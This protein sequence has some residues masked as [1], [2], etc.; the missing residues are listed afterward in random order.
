MQC[1][2]F[3]I[4]LA[5]LL[6]EPVP[7]WKSDIV[8]TWARNLGDELWRLSEALTKSDQIRIKYKQMNASVKQ[9]NGKVILDSSLTSVSAM[10]TRKINAVK[11]IHATAEKLAQEFNYSMIE[12]PEYK[13][14]FQY[15]SAKYSNF[16]YEQEQM[17]P[18][19]IFS[20]PRFAI[21]NPHFSNVTLEKDSHFYDINVNTNISCVHVPTNIYYEEKDALNA[22]LWSR[23]LNDIFTK[24]YKSDPSLS[25][26]YFGSSHGILRFFP[27]MPWNKIVVDTYDCRVRSWYIEAAT[28]S[29]D[30]IILFDVSGSMTGF[31]NYV[32]RRTLRSLLSTLS[33]NDYVNV[34]TFKNVT[35]QVV[36]CFVDLVQATPENIKTIV[37]ALEPTDGG[38]NHKVPLDG[39]ANLTEAYIKAF[40]T[41]KE[42]RQICN[43][44]STQGCNQLVMVI[45]DYVP[46]NLTEVFEEYN[47]EVVDN[48]TYIPVRVFTFLIGKEVTNVAEI[49]W[50]ACL[51]RGYFVHIHSVEEVQQQVLKYINVIAR[52]MILSKENPPP[53]WTHANIDDTRTQNWNLSSDMGK[54]DEDKLVT[55]VAIPAFDYKYNSEHNDAILLGVAGTDVP[56]DSIAKLAQPH[57]LGVNGYPLIVSN[58]GYLLLH[59][60]LIATIN[61]VLQENYNS[62]DFVEV[63]Q[64]DDGKGPRELGDKIKQ[65]RQALVDGVDGNMT[66]VEVLFHY[67]NMRR[68]ARV[69]HDYFY[70]KLEGT[71]FSMGIS[72]PKGYGDTELML[73]DNPLEAKQGKELTGINVTDYFRFSFRVHPDWVYCKYHYLEGHE[74]ETSEIEIWRFLSL[75]SKNEID[76]TK[77]QYT[78]QND[79]SNFTIE[80]HCGDATT[81][82]DLDDYYCTE[83]LVKQLVFDA[84]LTTPYFKEWHATTSEWDLARKYNVSVRFIAT[85]SGLTRW[86]YIFD[87][88]K[89]EYVNDDGTVEKNCSGKV[90]GDDYHNAIEE[91]WYKAAVLQHMIN[92]E[93]L[94]IATRLPILDDTIK[95]RPPVENED[96]DITMTATYAMFYRDGDSETPASVVG[97]Q[98]SYLKFHERFGN[99][100]N[101]TRGSG[102]KDKKE[103]VCGNG[104]YDCFLVDSSGYVVLSYPLNT[105]QVGQFF[106][107][108][109]HDTQLVLQYLIDMTVYQHV[110]LFNYQALCPISILQHQNSGWSLTSPFSI[111]GNFVRWLLSEIALLIMNWNQYTYA[112]TIDDEDTTTAM[113]PE[114]NETIQAEDDKKS[115][116]T[117]SCDHKIML[118]ILNQ[119]F[120]LENNGLPRTVHS[121]KEGD[122]HPPFWASYVAKT[123]MLLVVVERGDRDYLGDCKSDDD[124]RP[125]CKVPP[126]TKPRATEASTTSREPCHKLDLGRL[127]RRRLEG[128]FTYHEGERNITTCSSS[129]TTRRNLLL[130]L[131]TT[132]LGARAHTL[133]S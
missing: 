80:T 82:L 74:A 102:D 92:K 18:P 23:E 123:N 55:S 20:P 5:L 122:C 97:F 27:G 71:P 64:V 34:Y 28:C 16:E 4:L 107:V 111:A 73:K 48:N 127:P 39:N 133:L 109:N 15:C 25:W 68:I 47:R 13:A 29:K 45:T 72:L 106:G 120:F 104:K 40:T 100:T 37:D 94:V 119:K 31:K 11:C 49:R 41:L 32:A 114:A 81:Q 115:D 79:N 8:K 103:F 52:P 121:D 124:N 128:C 101:L 35:E 33:N 78:A 1:L 50:M 108:I 86:H 19:E 63:E 46:G 93:S 113:P 60:L 38:K 99:I 66:E 130:L 90:F 12:D 87:T 70:N 125:C 2:K 126:D 62:V 22:I 117:F 76:I 26:Q 30:V 118:Y 36:T 69:K 21:D 44:T 67:D 53:T 83:D 84:K 98:Y 7:A 91:T 95:N 65:L 24:N 110:E 9:K 85:S 51:N 57:Q 59:P 105:S 129:T 14:N 96:G 112:S 116:E 131:T 6:P 58:N 17:K 10:L 77:Q 88:D 61:G 3:A 54:P 89:N 56:I 75:L 132:L 43:V 42:R